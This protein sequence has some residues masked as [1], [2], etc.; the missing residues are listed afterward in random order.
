MTID[1]G[2]LHDLQEADASVGFPPHTLPFFIH[3]E[4]RPVCTLAGVRSPLLLHLSL[5]SP[6]A[7]PTERKRKRGKK[8]RTH[9]AVE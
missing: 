3:N 6:S 5:Q 2:P 9:Q 7:S 1:L 8:S 4:V